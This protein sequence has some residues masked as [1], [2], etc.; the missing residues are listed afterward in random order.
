MSK[1]LIR[2]FCIIAHVDHGKSTL[3]DRFLERT[4]AVPPREFRDQVLDSLD[5]E[6]ERGIT[7]KAVPVALTHKHEG[8]VYRLNLIDTPGHVDF[9]YEVTR[10]LSAC[11]GAILL[12]DA[13]QGVEAQTVANAY[14]AIDQGL[15]IVPVINK[16]DLPTARPEEVMEEMES[17][18]GIDFAEVMLCSAKTGQGVDQVMKAIVDRVPA[19]EGEDDKPLQALVFDSVYDDYRGVVVYVRLMQG[20]LRRGDMIRL[21][22]SKQRYELSEVGIFTPKMKPVEQLRAGE[23]G[24]VMAQIR[25]IHDVKVGDTVTQAEAHTATLRGYVEPRPMV[26]CGLY[27][28]DTGDYEQLR[29]ALAKFHLQDSAFSYE[30]ETSGALG[31]GFRCGFLGMLHMNVVQE[32]LERE[33]GLDLVQTA[34]NVTYEVPLLDGTIILVRNPSQLPEMGKVKEIREP[35]VRATILAPAE[36][37]GNVMRLAEERRG[38]YRSTEYLGS[39]RAIL[40]YDLPLAEIVFDFHDKLKSTTRGYGTMDYNFIGYQ[41]ENLVKVDVLVAGERLDAL[42]VICHRSRADARG[43]KLVKRL[44]Q[45]IPRHLFEV[46]LQAAIGSRIIARESIRALAKNVTAKCYGGDIT[47]KRKLWEKQKEGKK[48]MKSVGRVTVPQEAFLAVLAPD[49]D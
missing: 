14:H 32:R 5:I 4:G 11:E 12:V 43:R 40:Y 41:A 7:I 16:I 44:R 6:R 48:R 8:K 23:V 27:P 49:E 28:G 2:N 37:I 47:R 25:S 38:V 33:N 15:T 13:S 29:D 3:A 46:P 10:S 18:L 1:D 24:Y 26:F 42:S 45:E 31:F 20:T 34:P 36:C 35:V 17:I 19:P 39:Q 22:K 9:S 21:V 30:P